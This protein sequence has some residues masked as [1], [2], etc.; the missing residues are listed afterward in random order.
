MRCRCIVAFTSFMKVMLC[1]T[2]MWLQNW[3]E[4]LAALDILRLSL[5]EKKW[6][7]YRSQKKHKMLLVFN[8]CWIISQAWGRS[9]R[10]ECWWGG[11]PVGVYR[12]LI[13]AVGSLCDFFSSSYTL[14]LLMSPQSST[15]LKCFN[16]VHLNCNSDVPFW[17]PHTAPSRGASIHTRKHSSGSTR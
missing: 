12:W 4:E 5:Q 3:F 13:I 17:L 9:G 2:C 10:E 16:V 7:M 8:R 15:E 14:W 1:I 6:A 11:I